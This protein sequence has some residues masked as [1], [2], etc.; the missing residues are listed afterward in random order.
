MRLYYGK[1]YRMEDVRH[2]H[3][4]NGDMLLF[5]GHFFHCGVEN[6]NPDMHFR[7]HGEYGLKMLDHR[8]SD[9]QWWIFQMPIVGQKYTRK[10][11][12][13]F[14]QKV[15]FQKVHVLFK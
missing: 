4:G 10:H 3:V 1:Y 12:C 2:I 14:Q 8:E 15:V 7:V 6:T 13:F 5:N 9:A 11:Y